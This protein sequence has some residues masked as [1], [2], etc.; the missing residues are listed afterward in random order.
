MWIRGQAPGVYI[1]RIDAARGAPVVLRTDVAAFVGIARRGPLDLPLPIESWRQFVAHYGD[2]MAYGYLPAAVRGF[3]ANG[4]R[5][6]WVV[7]VAARQF[8]DDMAGGA[9]SASCIVHDRRGRPAWRFRASSPGS[10]GNGLDDGDAARPAAHAAREVV[11]RFRRDAPAASRG[12]AVGDLVELVQPGATPVARVLVAVDAATGRLEWVAKDP[13]DRTPAQRPWLGAPIG[14]PLVVTRIAYRIELYGGGRWL[15]AWRGVALPLEHRR[16][17]V[18]VLASPYPQGVESL[19][20]TPPSDE[21][22]A[23]PVPAWLCCEPLIASDDEL[24]PLDIGSDTWLTLAGGAD[25]LAALRID[26]FLGG[27][28]SPTASD[29]ARFEAR[30]GLAALADL[31]EVALVAMPDLMV[32][33]APDPDYEPVVPPPP[34]VSRARRQ[35]IRWSYISRV[36]RPSSR[37]V[38]RTTISRV[39]RP[40]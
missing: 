11:R 22:P 23:L 20:V 39:R 5:R 34:R 18:T 3:F 12:F 35:A 2:V 4:G 7:R 26:D 1:E 17:L 15:A 33:P 27:A 10:W 21:A 9:Q 32:Q 36:S 28:D 37:R 31:D 25:G 13:R 30:R 38:F 29:L 40:H 19:Q 14:A 8:D 24:A 16:G 6:C